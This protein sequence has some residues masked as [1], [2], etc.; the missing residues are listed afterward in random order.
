MKN[1]SNDNYRLHFAEQ[2]SLLNTYLFEWQRECL[3]KALAINVQMDGRWLH[4]ANV[5]VVHFFSRHK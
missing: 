5:V 3:A 4:F 1:Y 2:R